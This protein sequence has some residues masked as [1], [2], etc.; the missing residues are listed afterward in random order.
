MRGMERRLHALHHFTG[1][2]AWRSRRLRTALLR[3]NAK[4]SAT[5]FAPAP[6]RS[7]KQ[8]KLSLAS[9]PWGGGS[10]GNFTAALGIPPSMASAP[11][12]TAAHSSREHVL[13]NTMPPAARS[14]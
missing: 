5:L 3:S 2:P 12:A 10:D 1:E 9:A 4:M 11:W 13:F 7:A 6:N 8:M 14:I